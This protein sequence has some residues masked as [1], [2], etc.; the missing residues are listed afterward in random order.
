[1]W[2]KY[3]ITEATT[4]EAMPKFWFCLELRDIKM[5]QQSIGRIES[6]G[7]VSCASI[8]LSLLFLHPFTYNHKSFH[9]PLL[10][11]WYGFTCCTVS[12]YHPQKSTH[13]HFS[14]ASLYHG[15]QKGNVHYNVDIFHMVWG[16]YSYFLLDGHD[17]LVFVWCQNQLA[18]SWLNH[19]Q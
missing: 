14:Q 17:H 13:I 11:K 4:A 8:I 6:R 10:N 2:P 3:S 16:S 5:M 1:M 9:S 19:S 18:M 15:I 12:F 7:K